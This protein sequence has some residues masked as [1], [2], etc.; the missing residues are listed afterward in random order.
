M[1]YILENKYKFTCKNIMGGLDGYRGGQEA[2]YLF[3]DFGQ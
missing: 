2:V 1:F 3:D